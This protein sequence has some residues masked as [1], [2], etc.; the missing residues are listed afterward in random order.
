MSSL[1]LSVFGS[2]QAILDERP[3]QKFRTNKVQAL[4]I[5]LTVEAADHPI[6][7]RRDAL[8]ELLWPG[9]PLK[10]AQNNL[11]QTIYLLR[12]VIPELN[13]KGGGATAPFLISQH[14][15]VQINPEIVYDLDAAQF[16]R[17]LDETRNHDHAS[18]LS[19]TECQTQMEQAVSLY[20]G[21]F[22]TDFYLA[23]SSAFE[24]WAWAKREAFRRQALDALETLTSIHMRRAAYPQ[25]RSAAERQL[26]I[27]SLRESAYRQL[28]EILA[29]SGQASEAAA[30]YETCRRRLRDELGMEPTERTTAVYQQILTG[31]VSLTTQPVKGVRGY[32]LQEKIGAGSFGAVH[33]ALQPGVGREV[34][35][36]I[37]LPQYANQPDFIRRFEAEARL[38]AQ[39][40]HPH[41]V[42]LYDFWREPDGAYLVMR[43]LR[44]GSLGAALGSGQR[45]LEAV[46]Q[47]SNQ[48]TS[49]LAA[50]HRYGI[51]H[52]DIKPDNILLDE[53]GNSYLTDFGLAK[54]LTVNGSVTEDSVKGSPAYIS[55][56]QLTS[57][58]V[59]P[60]TDLY[61]LGIVLYEALTGERPYPGASLASLLFKHLNEPLP[62]VHDKRDDVPKAVDA[63]IQRATAKKPA[64]RYQD[65]AALAAA[66]AEAIQ[67]PVNGRTLFP[68][69]V[70]PDIAEADIFNPYKGLRPFREADAG[71]FFGRDDLIEQLLA[72]L[73]PDGGM[74]AGEQGGRG[75][76][77]EMTVTRSPAH[78]LTPSR[79]LAIVGPSGSGKS[80]VVKA[81]LVPRL[82]QNALPG[83]ENWYF[84]EMMPGAHPF[85]ELEA[86]L[87]R[88]A[89]NPPPSLQEPLLKDK[90]GLARTVKRA[91]PDD[92]ELF[93][94]IDQFEELFT[95]VEEE[96]IRNKFLDNLV[97]AVTEPRSRI[98]II[99]TLRADFYDRPLQ[100]PQLGELMRQ[101][102]EVVLPLTP[103]ELEQA[104]AGPAASVGVGL[105]PGLVTAII[106]DVNEQP[107]ALP[108][109]QYA[110]TELFERRNGRF[111]TLVAYE[112]IG[113]VLGALGRRAEAIYA[114]LDGPGQQAARQ[115]FLR[116]VTLGEGVEDTRRRV[117]QS[118]LESL[119]V[120]GK[121]RT[122]NQEPITNYQLP[123]TEYGKHRLLTFDRDPVTR[124][125]T[126]EVAHEALLRE[127]LRLRRWLDDSRHDVRQ[128]RLLAAAANEWLA[129]GQDKG[130]L[131][132]G[133]R[134]DQFASWARQT[135]LALTGSE[136]AFLQAS[137]AARQQRQ[138][139]EE[140]RRQRELE[141][142]RQLAEEQTQRAEEQAR[143]AN[144][145][146]LFAAGLAVIL[147]LAIGA[148]WLAV[149]NG[150]EAQ[151][152]FVVSE[153]T[154]LASQA[155]NALERG[156]GGDVA[157]LLALRSLQLGYSSEADMALQ[158]ALRI[159]FAQQQYLGHEG[160]VRGTKY[161]DDG[162][163]I[164]TSG[165]DQ[166]AR[167]WDAQT[168]AELIQFTGHQAV[169]NNVMLSP[170]GQWLATAS[171][172]NT[173]RIW[174]AATGEE[175]RRVILS[176][177]TGSSVV[178]MPD[179][180]YFVT[181]DAVSAKLWE[182]ATGDLVR[183]FIGH[184]GDLYFLAVSPDGQ[185]LATVSQDETARLWDVQTGA[186]IRQ[187]LGHTG[188][189][190]GVDFSPDGRYLLTTGEDGIARIWDVAS[191]LEMRRFTG[192]TS[193]I[194]DGK[195]S[196]D[197]RY[198]ATSGYDRTARIWDVATSQQ[199][200]LL[201][202]HTNTLGELAF[203]PDGQL[204]VTGSA[205]S[206]ARLWDIWT[207][208]EPVELGHFGGVH[209]QSQTLMSLS[210]DRR[211]TLI[212]RDQGDVEIWDNDQDEIIQQFQL[213]GEEVSAGAFSSDNRY[214]LIASSEGIVRLWNLQMESEER[215]FV[216][217]VGFVRSVAF[218]QNDSVVLTGGEDGDARLWNINSGQ[219]IMR[220]S[221]HGGPVR[222]VVFSPDGQ[223]VLTGSVDGTA[224]VW[225]AAT[226][227]LQHQIDLGVP[228]QAVAYLPDGN[229]VVVAGDDDVAH[230]W[231]LAAGKEIRP[232]VGHTDSVTHL[233]ISPDANLLLTGSADQTVRVWELATGEE[234]RRFGNHTSSILYVDFSDDGQRV[235]S[236]AIGFAFLWR[237]S[238]ADTI[239]FACDQLGRDFTAVERAFYNLDASRACARANATDDGSFVAQAVPTWTPI[240]ATPEPVDAIQTVVDIE[241]LQ[242]DMAFIEMGNPMQHIY[243]EAEDGMVIRPDNLDP[244][245]LA[246][247]LFTTA[248]FV[249]DDFIEP[250]FDRGP[251]PM[252]HP[253]GVA[254]GDWIKASGGG[255]Y[256]QKGAR[257]EIDLQFENLMPNSVYTVWCVSFDNPDFEWVIELPCGTPEGTENIFYTDETGYGEIRM[258]MAAFPPSTDEVIH[259]LA[260]AYH[261][262]GET[263]GPI[264][265]EFSKNAHVQLF[266][267]FLPPE[268]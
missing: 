222:S 101:S 12:K 97:T 72:R 129:V 23:D 39:L 255:T 194:Y 73:L 207:K 161:S 193:E 149:R 28:M 78:P 254:L 223:F 151:A 145:L 14:Q 94:V 138:A 109:L 80:S 208:S 206:T 67:T 148:A 215:Q 139:E 181:I 261:S 68:A 93:L 3:L 214:A 42:P 16:S 252:G 164:V 49:A 20:R 62:R 250:P 116:L 100:Y 4:L 58:P 82:R 132:R 159:G 201:R 228:I 234:I 173:A 48:L 166:T 95:L 218:S 265:G 127:W 179:S 225:D 242:M 175:V 84:I 184:T 246:M 260:I 198:I 117:L 216:G 89:V 253:I 142:A 199:I 123:I 185:Y 233:A 88:V 124:G 205:D 220:F 226:G 126:V 147:L 5:Y 87:L 104:I 111:L 91:L 65:A 235:Y 162:R 53:E 178:F 153:R 76:D 57:A 227:A 203:S 106:A 171:S 210:L 150:N 221:G 211:F 249:E 262:D 158:D 15:T 50:A 29:R 187:F 17:L 195:F 204:L 137:A 245:T 99:A 56:E 192:H 238:L 169:I 240:A 189:V 144:R 244:E 135:S 118:E 64:D 267:D 36:K 248:D 259:E 32:E 10:S 157:A 200:R 186:E 35:V 44:G 170:D 47:L 155:Q 219:E 180:R 98:R 188:W 63:V 52:R 22:L 25:A 2:F 243:V 113:G 61:S 191:G 167:I 202:G 112:E 77:G 264:V 38:V 18:L 163:L 122:K 256:Y 213:T 40:E 160:G 143:A 251:Y 43:Y 257:A 183:E 34:A 81:G 236:G 231:D 230:L 46:L 92:G 232:F 239:A 66:F 33:R 247:P 209:T 119:S 103:A 83:S 224:R 182:M 27:D 51:V 11:R 128:Q 59:S 19:C 266:Y 24:D 217:H 190:G 152:N 30:L 21:P 108:L 8:M 196:P 45:P 177:S 268:Q 54:V 172:D 69:V 134:L 131:L 120:N 37:I 114:N 197:G 9:L 229:Q 41:I 107:G 258:E 133:S 165:E 96:E 55:P 136:R 237:T 174:N 121:P 140:A 79:F 125:P 241:F 105:E 13:T 90:R 70:L 146:R 115:L 71:H 86:A 168:G 74:G 212:G 85:E 156:E 141:T 176:S 110:L 130:Y 26:A 263:H 6:A 60:A 31:E 7:H 1:S 75:A 102:A 154:R